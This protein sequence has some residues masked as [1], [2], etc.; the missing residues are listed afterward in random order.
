MSSWREVAPRQASSGGKDR[1]GRILRMGDGYLRT[2]LVVGATA[3]MRY[4]RQ[5]PSWVAGR[6]AQKPARLVSVAPANKK[7]WIAWALLAQQEM[8]RIPTSAVA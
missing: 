3:V 1:R 2:L 5:K 8:Y 7:A 4:A 6:L